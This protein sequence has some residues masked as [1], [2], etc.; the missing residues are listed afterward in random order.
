MI[1][2]ER[3]IWHRSI[4]TLV[5][6]LVCQEEKSDSLVLVNV[7]FILFFK[8][9]NIFVPIVTSDE[10]HSSVGNFQLIIQKMPFFSFE[11]DFSETSIRVKGMKIN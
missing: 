9:R 10:L 5:C 8:F 3:N 6:L 2:L 1:V 7:R 11:N 4:T